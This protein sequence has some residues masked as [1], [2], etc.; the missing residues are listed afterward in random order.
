MY[1]LAYIFIKNEH[2]FVWLFFVH[3]HTVASISTRFGMNAQGLNWG[4]YGTLIITVK[5]I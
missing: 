3:I 5:A 4:D 2:Q 1:I